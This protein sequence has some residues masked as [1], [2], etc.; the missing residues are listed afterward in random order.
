MG[1]RVRV[2][3]EM[4]AP[5]YHYSMSAPVTALRYTAADRPSAHLGKGPTAWICQ[6]RPVEVQGEEDGTYIPQTAYDDG[7][8]RTL[9]HFVVRSVGVHELIDTTCCCDAAKHKLSQDEIDLDGSG[10]WTQSVRWHG[11]LEPNRPSWARTWIMSRGTD[12]LIAR[13]TAGVLRRLIC[14]SRR[15]EIDISL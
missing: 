6:L 15:P 10:W 14:T 3:L 2:L 8:S 11:D 1:M 9:V 5:A 4:G 13:A 7:T 12:I